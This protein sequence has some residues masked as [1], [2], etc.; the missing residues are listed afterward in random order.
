MYIFLLLT[1]AGIQE[2]RQSKVAIEAQSTGST[3]AANLEDEHKLVN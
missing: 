1:K 3:P 2:E